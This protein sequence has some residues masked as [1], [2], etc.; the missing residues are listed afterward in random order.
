MCGILHVR[1]IICTYIYIY[2]LYSLLF[3]F[4]SILYLTEIVLKALIFIESI[5]SIRVQSSHS[6]FEQYMY[7]YIRLMVLY[8]VQY[9]A[10][11]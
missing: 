4:V 10:F 3:T 7:E 6:I 1:N 8:C 11:Y 5:E 9:C 2:I